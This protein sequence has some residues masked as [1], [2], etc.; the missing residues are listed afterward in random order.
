MNVPAPTSPEFKSVPT[1]SGQARLWFLDQLEP[2]RSDYNVAIGWRITGALDAAALRGAVQC[3]VDRHEALR[4]TFHAVDGEPWQRIVPHREVEFAT[5]DLSNVA[6]SAREA[7]LARCL[8]EEIRTPFD[9]A[10]G[11]L[12]RA[13][14]IRLAPEEH[15]FAIIRHHVSCGGDSGKI[16]AREMGAA[17]EALRAGT[18][19]DLP[20]VAM[21]YADYVAW[22]RAHLTPERLEALAAYWRNR[23]SGAPA[24]LALPIDKPRPVVRHTDG[25]CVSFHIDAKLRSALGALAE[26][27]GVTLHMTLLAAFQVLLGR[28]ADQDDVL[29]GLPVSAQGSPELRDV[30]GF[31]VNTVVHRGDLADDPTFR[32]LLARTATS[33][34]EAYRH[35][36]LSIERIVEVAAPEREPGRDPLFQAMFAL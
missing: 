18:A 15:V 16:T 12:S 13:R 32:E 34:R 35:R 1:S 24:A 23:L 28:H 10:K 17:Y 7:E 21:Q 20:P 2:G 22:Q 30:I 26:S 19:P 5:I 3:V 36:D 8:A 11:P 9:L 31:L 27:A 25:A 33:A 4:T 14:L 6:A 29:V